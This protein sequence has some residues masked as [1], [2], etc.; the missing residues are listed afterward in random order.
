[1]STFGPSSADQSP[2]GAVP[3]APL[4]DPFMTSISDPI[5]MRNMIAE[6]TSGPGHLVLEHLYRLCIV[7]D[8]NME[9]PAN[10]LV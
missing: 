3:S 1:M 6:Q 8:V 7:P 10:Q 2:A 4:L 5:Q 9:L